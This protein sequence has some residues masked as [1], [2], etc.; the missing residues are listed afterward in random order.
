MSF[1][2]IDVETANSSRGSI[3][4]VGVTIVRDSI[5]EETYSWLC[6]PPTAVDFFSPHNI[7]VHGIRPAMVA[8]QP[9]FAQLWPEVH[10]VVGDLP[11]VAHNA[12]FDSGA[13][14]EA[15]RHS[16]I[17]APSWE[18][19][20]SLAMS[21]KHL[22]LDGYRLPDVAGALDISLIAHHDAAADARA[23][24]DIVL[25]L[26]ARAGVDSLSDLEQ[27]T[28]FERRRFDSPFRPAPQFS[29]PRR[30]VFSREE[31]V[32]PE[33]SGTD[34]SLPLYGQIV[35]FTG[36]L[37]SM[38]RQQVWD[39]IAA[40]GAT[41]AKNVTKRTTCLV[42]GDR[43]AGRDASVFTTSK[44]RR[45]AELQMRGQQIEVVDEEMLLSYLHAK[46]EEQARGATH[47]TLTL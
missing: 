14:R 28:V 24:A 35:V 17:E 1:A 31:L 32:M 29:R 43:F 41:P 25:A 45:V 20:C 11:L 23:A 44:A 40:H 16:G 12:G 13:I 33:I 18:F 8:D 46:V 10:Q 22:D 5:R 34:P 15:C 39:A 2:A 6:R 47:L 21:R 37:T 36:D 19:S 42:I 7:R 4:A 3:C 9:T 38:T 26:A 27:M 30:S